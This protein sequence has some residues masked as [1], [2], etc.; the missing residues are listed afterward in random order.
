MQQLTADFPCR[1]SQ[2]TGAPEWESGL[3]PP[4]FLIDFQFFARWHELSLRESSHVLRRTRN[5]DPNKSV[6]HEQQF[7][8]RR[9]G[10]RPRG[11][12]VIHGPE[13]FHQYQPA[14]TA[15]PQPPAT[16]SLGAWCSSKKSGGVFLGTPGRV[17]LQR[18]RR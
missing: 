1:S 13:A 6:E 9:P 4:S 16:G 5:P 2:S 18:R 3:C 7:Y 8:S 14:A 15:P 11:V 10:L 17:A 12:R